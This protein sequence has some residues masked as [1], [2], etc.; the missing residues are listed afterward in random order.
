MVLPALVVVKIFLQSFSGLES[1]AIGISKLFRGRKIEKS[2]PEH[3]Q[4]RWR[5]WGSP[6]SGNTRNTRC[7][8]FSNRLSTSN[9]SRVCNCSILEGKK[10][11]FNDFDERFL[12]FAAFD[13]QKFHCAIVELSKKI[14]L[15]M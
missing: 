10:N 11:L 3:E 2:L 8:G 15:R 12:Y 1:D 13:Q 5:C 14:Y 9:K 7:R 4:T 6:C